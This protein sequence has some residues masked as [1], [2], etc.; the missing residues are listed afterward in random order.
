M[1]DAEINFD[2]ADIEP[3]ITYG[4]NPGL[5]MG[6]ND[7]IPAF[8]GDDDTARQSYEKS[9]SYMGFHE[10]QKLKGI[11]VDY[12]SSEAVP[13]AESRTSAHLPR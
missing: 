4:T 12:V 9:L 10:G 13:T 5:G 3:R 8:E 11:P 2:A 1:F 6:I 7:A